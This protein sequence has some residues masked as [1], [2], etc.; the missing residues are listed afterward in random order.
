MYTVEQILGYTLPC[1]TTPPPSIIILQG[2]LYIQ[3]EKLSRFICSHYE[4]QDIY[5]QEEKQAAEQYCLQFKY[6][7]ENVCFCRQLICIKMCKQGFERIYIRMLLVVTLPK[8]RSEIVE[9]GQRVHLVL[10]A[11][12]NLLQEC[13]AITGIVFKNKIKDKCNIYHC[14]LSK[15]K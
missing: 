3:Y 12:K 4:L 6:A 7:K 9:S 10:S 15:L 13:F 14:D 2:I 5:C 11:T 1:P 8:W